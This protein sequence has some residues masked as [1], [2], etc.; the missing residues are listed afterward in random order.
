MDRVVRRAIDAGIDP[1]VAIQ[2][3]TLN[4]A[5]YFGLRHDLGSIAPGRLADVLFVEDLRDFR[6]HQ[7]LADGREAGALPRYEYPAQAFASIRL[8]RP[9][10]ADDLR[11]QAS[12]DRATVRA[13]GVASGKVTTEHLQVELPVVEGEVP[14]SVEHDVAKAASIERHGGPGTIGL[15]FVKGLG[16]T[17]GAVASSVAHDNHNLLVAGMTDA[18]MIF[19]VERLAEAGG[20]MIAVADGEVLALVELPIGGLISDRSVADLAEQAHALSEAYRRLGSPI[21][22]AEMIF[23]FLSLGVIPALRLTNRGLVDGVAFEL[24]AP[25]L[26]EA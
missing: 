22:N 6:P 10:T 16:L 5:E 7:V 4:G 23:S 8:A 17:R 14:A 11:I 1:L 9:V 2:M 12:G 26:S 24:V 19:A 15:G 18:D 3:A 25:L 13:I 21:E 20:G